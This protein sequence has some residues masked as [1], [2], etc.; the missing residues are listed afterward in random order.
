[1]KRI[2]GLIV[3][4]A[5]LIAALILSQNR[6]VPLK[7]S[8]FLEADDIRPGSRVGGRVKQVLIE[9][10]QSVSK[11]E[12]LFELEPYDLLERRAEAVAGLAEAKANYEKLVAG[13]RT[14]EIAKAQAQVD[15]LKA[16]LTLLVNGPRQQEID[17]AVAELQLADAEYRL[18][19]AKQTRIETLFAKKSASKDELDTANTELQATAARK[20]VRQKALDLLKEGT[21][22]EEIEEARAKLK[23]AEEDW[24]LLKNGNRREDIAQAKAAVNK[25][26][27]S[28]QVI[29]DQ[30]QELKVFSPLDG[31]IEA[32]TLQPGD[33]VGSNV[34]VISILDWNHLWVRCYVPEN[35]LDIH[36]DQEV[37]VTIDSYPDKVFKGRVT[38][39]SRQA[40]FVP[41]NVQTPE[42]RSKQV[43][44]IKVRI[45]GQ[46][47]LL[48]PGMSADVWLDKKDTRP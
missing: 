10:G 35:H 3:L 41:R 12:L 20:E 16:R 45:E 26:E 11:G 34:P 25:A 13:F 47:K 18:A 5:V 43:F 1:M 32:V 19:K 38:F 14:E 40:E 15:Q 31:T 24:Q 33:L 8:G 9:E 27:A 48:R 6:Y 23:Q 37:D 44:R 7:V 29:D 39:V 17:S 21:R 30:I 46:D 22:I 2:L 28:L 42:E 36:I 4:A